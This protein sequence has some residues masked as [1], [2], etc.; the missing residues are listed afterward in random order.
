MTITNTPKKYTQYDKNLLKH[1]QDINLMI[2]EDFIELCDKNNIEYISAYGTTL[3]AVRHEGFIPWDDDIDIMMT[4]EEFEK[5]LNVMENYNEKYELFCLEKTPDYCYLCA[6]FNL[7]GTK[8]L[9]EFHQNEEIDYGILMDI[10]I[11]SNY[12]DS[13]V[14]EYLYSIELNLLKKMIWIE[15]ITYNDI[16]VSKFKE[17]MGR[18]IKVFLKLFQVNKN[19]IKKKCI[20]LLKK[21]DDSSDAFCDL[22]APYKIKPL[23]KKILFPPK[24]MKFESLE[25]NVPNDYDSYLKII[26]G[27]YMELPPEN[28]RHNHSLTIDFGIY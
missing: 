6:K 19:N 1:I 14:G 11:L 22:G 4:Y 27:N 18:F 5:L 17:I 20:K 7:K 2:L 9:D 24:K 3:G 28:E 25:I 26:Y 15:E 16:Y 12:P 13:K 23:S 21:Y 10:F 8:I